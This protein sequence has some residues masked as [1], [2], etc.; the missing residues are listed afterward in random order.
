ML[1]L[2]NLKT[3]FDYRFDKIV[4]RFL[5]NLLC[6]WTDC[7]VTDAYVIQFRDRK[8][9]LSRFLCV[10]VITVFTPSVFHQLNCTNLHYL[11]PRNVAQWRVEHCYF[12][13]ISKGR[14]S[15]LINA[16]RTKNSHIGDLVYVT[17]FQEQK[18]TCAGNRNM[19]EVLSPAS[20]WLTVGHYH[21]SAVSFK[22]FFRG[23]VNDGWLNNMLMRCSQIRL[24]TPLRY[25]SSSHHSS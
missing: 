8:V 7:I 25:S 21:V 14:S 18:V 17:V 22:D 3:F 19:A 12:L 20:N 5:R 15:D 13:E 10:P 6:T 16:T 24:A 11:V 23:S 9:Y 1:S 4:N 2:P